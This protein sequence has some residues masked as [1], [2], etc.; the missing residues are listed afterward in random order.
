MGSKIQTHIITTTF[1]NGKS[2]I[3]HNCTSRNRAK[4]RCIEQKNSSSLIILAYFKRIVCSIICGCTITAQIGINHIGI[5][6]LYGYS[7]CC[8]TKRLVLPYTASIIDDIN[9]RYCSVAESLGITYF[10]GEGICCI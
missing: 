9:S 7:S 10:I 1:V 8:R 6:T 4:I 3:C 2:G 5:R